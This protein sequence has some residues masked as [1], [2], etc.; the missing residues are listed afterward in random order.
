MAAVC[1]ADVLMHRV[2]CIPVTSCAQVA[3]TLPLPTRRQEP[4]LR[5]ARRAAPGRCAGGVAPH[6]ANRGPSAGEHSAPVEFGC[7]CCCCSAVFAWWLGPKPTWC[8]LPHQPHATQLPCC[9]P[10]SLLTLSLSIPASH[11]MQS[12]RARGLRADF[13]SST[14][15][16]AD[17]RR[18]LAD[19]QQRS[20]QTQVCGSWHISMRYLGTVG[21]RASCQA[22]WREPGCVRSASPQT[23][24]TTPHPPSNLPP[25]LPT[26]THQTAAALRHPRAAG[27]GGF[28]ALPAQR[29]RSGRPA[30]GCGG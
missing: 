3:A 29:I 15:S 6:C 18:V 11:S 12:L 8:L 10:S 9:L 17:R 5:P 14:R 24:P 7:C 22:A 27:H 1:L 20:P 2:C 21:C 16:E 13:L 28:H 19:L 23:T 25:P 30:A 4:V 26:P